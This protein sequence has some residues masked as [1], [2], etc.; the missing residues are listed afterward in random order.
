MNYLAL[1]D[2]RQAIQL[3][4]AMEQPGRLLALF[5]NISA[6]PDPTPSITGNAA[7]DEVLRTLAPADLARLLRYLR[8][9][10]ATA[11][12]SGVAQRVLH[13]VMKFRA[14]EDIARAF[15]DDSALAA[16][17]TSGGALAK[18]GSGAGA[19]ALKDWVEAMIP[20]TERHLARMDR[21]LQESYI[22]DYMLGEMD[23]GMFG[24][25]G[26]EDDGF[27]SK[28]IEIDKAVAVAV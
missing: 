22:V 23:D 20:Y 6:T 2:Y 19:T 3:A 8:D 26:D 24:E 28:L 21:L 4:L 1:H 16:V 18:T 12:T 27:G 7:V 15:G 17:E 25:L 10:N 13:A 5:K 14:A 9:W 11:R